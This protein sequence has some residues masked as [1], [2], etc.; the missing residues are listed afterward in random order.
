[1]RLITYVVAFCLLFAGVTLTAPAKQPS[2]PGGSRLVIGNGTDPHTLDPYG[3]QSEP[4]YTVYKN[5]FEPLV[6]IDDQNRVIP[7]QAIAWSLSEDG[8]Q[9][10]FTLREGLRWSNGDALTARDFVFA[11]RYAINPDN[12]LVRADAL[13]N[14][15]IVNAE[16][17]IN[18]RKPV[19]SLGVQ[20]VDDS[21]LLI[22]LDIPIPYALTVIR[23]FIYPLHEKSIAANPK[24]W[25]HP[26]NMVSN[27]PYTLHNWVINESITLKKNPYYYDSDSVRIEEVDF[28]P[29]SSESELKRYQANELHIATYIPNP[30]LEKLKRD[31]PEQLVSR[32]V[33]AT[34]F[35][36]FNTKDPKLADAR[37]RRALSLAV[38]RP[39]ITNRIT[40]GGEPPAYF[41]TPP[42][43]NE[44][45]APELPVIT[46]SDAERIKEAKKLYKEAGYGS[47]NPLKLELLYNTR[48]IHKQIALA[49]NDMWKKNLGVKLTLKNMDFS[50]LIAEI[51]QGKFELARMGWFLTDPEPCLMLEIFKTGHA[52]NNMQYSN[53]EFDRIQKQACTGIHNQSRAPL[54]DSL[55]HLLASDAPIIPVHFYNRIRLVKP[56]VGGFPETSDDFYVK[57]LYFRQP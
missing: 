12:A 10:R 24:K 14:L 18:R 5:L 1:M 23:R 31:I 56:S 9:Y 53:P 39:L 50:S 20:A 42:Q 36:I 27:G 33:H 35:Y 49:I 48:E 17:I 25:A 19:E 11:L 2:A 16:D 52:F 4:E 38:D 8:R 15:H 37:L 51:G 57:N 30:M 26:G 47:D 6:A 40:R 43:A 54:F 13:K 7:A 44:F 45:T 29:L 21:T 46:Q 41:A 32:P 28:L 3:A 55:E 22:N 34:Y